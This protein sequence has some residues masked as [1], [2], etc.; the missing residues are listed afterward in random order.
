MKRKR[1][2]AK[3]QTTSATSSHAAAWEKTRERLDRALRSAGRKPTEAVAIVE[4]MKSAQGKAADELVVCD[5]IKQLYVG[6]LRDGRKEYEIDASDICGEKASKHLLTRDAI[7][8][9][10]EYEQQIAILERL[11]NQQGILNLA[12]ACPKSAVAIGCWS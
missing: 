5:E 6:L 4:R 3:Q 12:R 2:K 11:V 10:Q 7:G 8:A 1:A 9:I